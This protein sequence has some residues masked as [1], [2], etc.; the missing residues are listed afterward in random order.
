MPL[1]DTAG[2]GRMDQL[3][4]FLVLAGGVGGVGRTG[5]EELLLFILLSGD[6]GRTGIDELLLFILLT[7]SL[8]RG[9]A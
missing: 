9:H 3:L 1:F 4:L 8:G 2:T 5:I 7:G 6:I